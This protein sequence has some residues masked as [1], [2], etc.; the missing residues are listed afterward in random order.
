MRS[1]PPTATTTRGVPIG[2]P[3]HIDGTPAEVQ[4]SPVFGD[5]SEESEESDPDAEWITEQLFG[6]AEESEE[7]AAE[8]F[9]HTIYPM[10]ESW[11]EDS[12]T[13]SRND[14]GRVC[15]NDP[16]ASQGEGWEAVWY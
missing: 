16:T 14:D 12:R 11:S 7:E 9:A 1:G 13:V 3:D 4:W 8:D 15:H 5:T 6:E 10:D 2:I